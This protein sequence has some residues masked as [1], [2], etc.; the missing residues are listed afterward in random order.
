MAG[1]CVVSQTSLFRIE[2]VVVLRGLKLN[3]RHAVRAKPFSE[4]KRAAK[5]ARLE[6][7]YRQH[8]EKPPGNVIFRPE[9]KRHK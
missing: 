1:L 2:W 9:T 5:L 4:I 7:V 6:P 8:N 3:A